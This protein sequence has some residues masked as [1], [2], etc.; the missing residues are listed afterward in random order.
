MEQGSYQ[1]FGLMIGVSYI[2]MQAVMY[3]NVDQFSHVY[4]GLTRLY[5]TLLMT[6]PMALI[7]L[8]FMGSMYKNRRLN[9]LIIGASIIAIS[10]VLI[11]LRTQTFVNDEQ[12]M[13]AMIPHHSSAIMVSQA[14]KLKDPK[15]RKL[16][17]GIIESQEREIA[18]MKAILVRMEK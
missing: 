18:E 16:A 8:A 2:I 3:L 9:G 4:I 14:A 6:A 12:Y 13:K 15:L 5:M 1:K 7:M 17:K 11:L 10:G